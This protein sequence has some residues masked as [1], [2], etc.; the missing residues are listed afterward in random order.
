M[1]INIKIIILLYFILLLATNTQANQTQE[2]S[3]HDELVSFTLLTEEFCGYTE[4]IFRIQR[5]TYEQGIEP[6]IVVYNFTTYEIDQNK[7]TKT[8]EKTINKYS[9]TKTGFLN[10]SK[11]TTY[12][13][14]VSANE[15]VLFW[16]VQGNCTQQQTQI[17]NTQPS[18]NA[19]NTT[20]ATNSSFEDESNNAGN[21]T[22][23][24]SNQTINTTKVEQNNETIINET[25]EETQDCLLFTDIYTSA[26]IYQPH[27]QMT[28]QFFLRPL[29]QTFSITYW[30]ED[31][32]GNIVKKNITTTN[33]HEKT[34][35]FKPIPQPEKAY[36]VKA[37]FE[38]TC[39]T[40]EKEKLIVV[41]NNPHEEEEINSETSE[42]LI[43]E[44]I[45]SKETTLVATIFAQ[46]GHTSK[47]LIS[48]KQ[49]TQ[50]NK[51]VQE[52]IKWYL[53]SKQQQMRIKLP[54]TRTEVPS[55]LVCEGL[56]ELVMQ[57]IHYTRNQPSACPEIIHTYTRN[58]YTSPNA[59]WYVR[60]QGEG[61]INLL[62]NVNNKTAKEQRIAVQGEETIPLSISLED[63][64]SIVRT[65]ITQQACI[66]E[67]EDVLVLKTKKLPTKTT[68]E[69]QEL[70][71]EQLFRNTT[72]T[73]AP[74][75]FTAHVITSEKNK[76]ITSVM[77][78][79]VLVLAL[80][81]LV[82][83]TRYLM[84]KRLKKQAKKDQ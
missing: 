69:K 74:N 5:V 70:P 48:C 22:N 38:D 52:E 33:I 81:S 23:N 80:V 58:Q 53:L 35:T 32:Q 49:L 76:T 28:I 14:E 61:E 17:N 31:L 59:T 12:H 60:I 43:I 63:N 25:K 83:G 13:V 44:S 65:R 20:I 41:S 51:Q 30:I 73:P 10:S 40:Q 15:Q 39:G 78:V 1:N 64:T 46:K 71:L 54:L 72:T 67:K 66:Q 82:L 7:T 37:V 77:Q 62:I 8:I 6:L 3:I 47:T 19:T 18:I 21:Q 26:D 2:L 11:Q 57:D 4:N 56:G 42:Q 36:T 27:D 16:I 79:I 50:E 55:K 24:N 45:T 9:S 75:S 29:T 34:Y 84:T 68:P